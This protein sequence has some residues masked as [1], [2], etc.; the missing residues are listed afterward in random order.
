MPTTIEDYQRIKETEPYRQLWQPITLDPVD[1]LASLRE[2]VLKINPKR[3]PKWRFRIAPDV[4]MQ[5]QPSPEI[6]KYGWRSKQLF[7][8]LALQ[9]EGIT[10]DHFQSSKGRDRTVMLDMF[11][12][13]VAADVSGWAINL[14]RAYLQDID[15]QLALKAQI[16]SGIGRTGDLDASMMFQPACLACGK[17][18]TDPVSRARWIGPECAHNHTLGLR[19]L[20]LS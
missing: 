10:K 13:I 7:D 14:N 18:L 5:L 11:F 16:V 3:R 15:R 2:T 8:G 20:K 6:N 19:I 4:V 17:A 12:T 1:T 9:G